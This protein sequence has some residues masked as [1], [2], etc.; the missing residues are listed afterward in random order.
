MGLPF[1]LSVIQESQPLQ[2]HGDWWRTLNLQFIMTT[3]D[4]FVCKPGLT[5]WVQG[6]HK[7]S[8]KRQAR[9]TTVRKQDVTEEAEVRERSKDAKLLA[10]KM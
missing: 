5:I 3:P 2:A 9:G 10:L 4:A 7:G 6:D 8:Y 1:P